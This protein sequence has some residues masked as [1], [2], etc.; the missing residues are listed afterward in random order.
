MTTPCMGSSDTKKTIG[1]TCTTHPVSQLTAAGTV[2]FSE[3]TEVGG[4]KL[5][6]VSQLTAAGTMVHAV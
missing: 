4:Q 6:P 2:P 3:R 5:N 1:L